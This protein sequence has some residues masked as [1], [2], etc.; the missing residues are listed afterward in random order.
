LKVPAELNLVDGGVL[1]VPHVDTF[2]T[3]IVGSGPAGAATAQALA[4]GGMTVAVLEEGPYVPHSQFVAD[5]FRSMAMLYRD[6]G[7]SVMLGNAPMP[8]LQGR[9]VGGTSVING[10]ISWRLPKSVWAEWTNRDP[11]L[12]DALPWE[13]LETHAQSIEEQL[14]IA[15]TEER[16]A[17]PKNLL[18]AKGADALGLEH[19]PIARNVRGCR[20][21]GRCLQGCPEG[22]KMSMER[23]MLP[24]ACAHGA[25][26]F[27]STSATR[28]LVES[29]RATGVLATSRGG[30]SVTL[31]AR[32]RVILA[33]SAVQ[34]PMLLAASGIRHGPV[35]EHFQCHP[36]VSVAARFSD[37]IRMWSGATQG[38]EVIGLRKDG[39]KFEVLGFD[40]A[41][42]AS[43]L[44][45]VGQALANGIDD[46]DHWLSWGAAIRAEGEGTVRGRKRARVRFRMTTGDMRKVRRGVC[47][48]GE[49]LLAAGAD[50]VVP[51]VHGWHER[52]T[53]R[54]VMAKFEEEGP[55]DPHAYAMAVTHMFGTCRM[56][57]QSGNSVVGSD[58]RHHAVDRL[59]VVDSSVFPSNT[60]VNPQT[61]ILTLATHASQ[62]ML[63]A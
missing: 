36:G 9:A 18:M 52:V 6:M 40:L 38:H 20:G 55:L 42:L 45:G 19:R 62:H 8:F 27:H 23:T 12:R 53:D 57:S 41:I 4:R 63:N 11:P 28:I 60:G 54:A 30:G 46:M 21:L 25:R 58:L 47:L 51:G 48:L 35:G 56:G 15:P 59:H 7:A 29:G 14:H 49:M 39:L 10:A 2:D 44:K 22:N 43:R 1:T 61:A 34:S 37:P 32:E 3:V 31:R 17:G 26:I 50:F 13:E 24:S 33:A 5:A 16:V